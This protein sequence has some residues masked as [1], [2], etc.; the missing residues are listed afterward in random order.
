MNTE[1][2][3]EDPKAPVADAPEMVPGTPETAS[4]EAPLE[5]L[6]PGANPVTAEV[7]AETVSAVDEPAPVA[8]VSVMDESVA[9]F[10]DAE[11][12]DILAADDESGESLFV[13]EP[14][15]FAP[16]PAMFEAPPAEFVVAA[17]VEPQPVEQ[18]EQPMTD[19]FA[20]MEVAPVEPVLTE[21]VAPEPV[22]E[23]ELEDLLPG[24]SPV[25]GLAEG[26][27]VTEPVPE[28][29]PVPEAAPEPVAE[30]EVASDAETDAAIEALA[31]TAV[32]MVAAETAEILTEEVAESWDAA[33]APEAE[34]AA[35]APVAEAL[36]EPEADGQDGDAFDDL[37]PEV[38]PLMVAM[39]VQDQAESVT[40]EAQATAVLGAV[41][42][43]VAE[44]IAEAEAE[45]Q[46][47]RE[48]VGARTPVELWWKIW[49]RS[50][51]FWIAGT[52]P[53]G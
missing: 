13:P 14:E 34:P 39:V 32:E 16:V 36:P 20:P 5:D 33:P 10:V 30:P 48:S 8:E 22:A 23:P 43:A 26:E 3:F 15:A 38:D 40:T 7:V 1:P 28:P 17:P 6:L 19:G 53:R 52:K 18:P 46:A 27:N 45:R 24:A 21:A 50:L 12:A 31:D 44:I 37:L 47:G 11:A 2:P 4:G 51:D 9:A 42:E 49:A 35:A 29:A 25:A 41:G